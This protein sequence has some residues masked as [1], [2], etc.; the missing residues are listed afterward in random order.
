MQKSPKWH[1]G[2]LYKIQ[3][4]IVQ[5]D[6]SRDMLDSLCT[7]VWQNILFQNSLVY[8]VKD[9]SFTQIYSRENYSWQKRLEKYLGKN[10]NGRSWQNLCRQKS[11]RSCCNWRDNCLAVH[12][13]F[14]HFVCHFASLLRRGLVA[15]VPCAC[16]HL[17]YFPVERYLGCCISFVKRPSLWWNTESLRTLLS[18]FHGRVNWHLSLRA[19]FMVV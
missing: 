19:V 14:E 17:I 10:S 9:D 7:I 12:T 6:F 13:T 2:R 15:T 1:V 18:S 11:H 8:T 16:F 4:S 5:S 3:S